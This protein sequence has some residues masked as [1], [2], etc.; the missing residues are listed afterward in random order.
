MKPILMSL[1]VLVGLAAGSARIACAS[2]IVYSTF[3]PAPAGGKLTDN[4]LE[5]IN[6]TVGSDAGTELES[7]TQAISPSTPADPAVGYYSLTSSAHPMLVVPVLLVIVWFQS[8]R[9]RGRS[10]CRGL[11]GGFEMSLY[12]VR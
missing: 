4:A 10:Q 9:R 7:W 5:I 2:S 6:I 11:V 1:V 12:P 3:D 8:Q